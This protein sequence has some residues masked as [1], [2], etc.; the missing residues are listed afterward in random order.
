MTHNDAGRTID[1]CGRDFNKPRPASAPS[2][3]PAIPSGGTDILDRIAAA[4][5]RRATTTCGLCGGDLDPDQMN[6]KRYGF[7]MC[8]SCVEDGGL[9]EIE[10]RNPAPSDDGTVYSDADAG[11]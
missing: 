5:D 2:S 10:D 7:Y 4:M 11:M 6:V 9:D 8:Q 1:Q 3:M